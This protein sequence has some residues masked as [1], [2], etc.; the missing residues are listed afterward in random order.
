MAVQWLGLRDFTAG[1]TGSI[2]SQGTKIPHA[3]QRGQKKPKQT[4]KQTNRN[5]DISFQI[6]LPASL[7]NLKS[8]D[9]LGSLPACCLVLLF[10]LFF[11]TASCFGHGRYLSGPWGP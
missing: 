6:W 9:T 11:L 1:G 4:N 5:G 10:G 3:V 2:P 7:E 8:L